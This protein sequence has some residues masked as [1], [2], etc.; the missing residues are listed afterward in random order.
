MLKYLNGLM[1][2]PADL[3]LRKLTASHF[4]VQI[5]L[6]ANENMPNMFPIVYLNNAYHHF[7][8]YTQPRRK[9]EL[10]Q[11]NVVPMSTMEQIGDMLTKLLPEKPFAKFHN[12]LI[13]WLCLLAFLQC[14]GVRFEIYQRKHLRKCARNMN[15]K[16]ILLGVFFNH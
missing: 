9:G 10:P 11:I 7:H 15:H 14:E 5:N 2:M 12:K 13:R 16:I 6:N 4:N 8:E 3:N 1:G